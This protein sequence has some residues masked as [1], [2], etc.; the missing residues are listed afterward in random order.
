ML[1]EFAFAEFASRIEMRPGVGE[2]RADDNSNLSKDFYLMLAISPSMNKP[3][4]EL[5][6]VARIT[7]KETIRIICDSVM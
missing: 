1:C 4:C 5:P 2:I 6:P 3:E 7:F